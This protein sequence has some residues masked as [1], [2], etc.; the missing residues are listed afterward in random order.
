MCPMMLRRKLAY[1]NRSKLNLTKKKKEEYNANIDLWSIGCTLMYIACNCHAW[2]ASTEDQL[3]ELHDKRHGDSIRGVYEPNGEAKYFNTFRDLSP[4]NKTASEQL[5]Q[6][7]IRLLMECFKPLEEASM[8]EYFAIV[9]QIK[10][11]KIS[12]QVDINTGSGKFDILKELTEGTTAEPSKNGKIFALKSVTHF[13]EAL[14]FTTPVF[15]SLGP[16]DAI[17]IKK[18]DNRFNKSDEVGSNIEVICSHCHCVAS[19]IAN[20]Q[21]DDFNVKVLKLLCLTIVDDQIFNEIESKSLAEH[22]RIV[23]MLN[24]QII[25][26]DQIFKD[27][28]KTDRKIELDALV[29]RCERIEGNVQKNVIQCMKNLQ[30]KRKGGKDNTGLLYSMCSAIKSASA[31][32]KNT[33]IY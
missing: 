2:A 21:H 18:L 4:I 15:F 32:M 19:L 31:V 33:T 25:E 28:S 1:E 16:K 8:D 6:S 22:E 3:S 14:K 23:N 11:Q 26:V 9:D 24:R 20:I 27:V 17:E 7:Y 29:K 30:G 10:K 5:K 12:Y 13:C